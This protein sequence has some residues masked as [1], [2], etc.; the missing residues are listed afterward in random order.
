MK[1]IRDFRDLRVW[2]AGIELVTDIYK[3]TNGFPAAERYGLTRQMRRAA[4]SIPANIAE[5]NGRNTPAAYL[6]HLDIARGSLSEFYTELEIAG[7]L[8]YLPDSQA[9]HLQKS[10]QSLLRQLL[11]L[12]NALQAKTP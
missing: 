12:R 4:V 2:Q 11:A 7:R 6:N 8:A 3:Q 9:A 5:G 10:C 1:E